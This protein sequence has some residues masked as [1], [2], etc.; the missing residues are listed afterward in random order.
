MLTNYLNTI[1]YRFSNLLSSKKVDFDNYDLSKIFEYYTAIKLSEEYNCEFLVYDDIDPEYKEKNGLT[2]I[3]TGIDLCNCKDTLVQ[4]KIYSKTIELNKIT[5]FL[6]SSLDVNEKNETYVRWKKMI[7]A[8]NSDSILSKNVKK[9]EKLFLDKIYDRNEMIN[10][11]KK[12]KP[13][14]ANSKYNFEE[15]EYQT[16]VKTLISQNKNCVICLPTGTG[17][18]QILIQYL[19]KNEKYLILV[20]LRVLLHQICKEIKQFRFD[21]FEDV[22]LIGDDKKVYEINKNIVICVYNSFSQ[23]EKLLTEFLKNTN[24]IF[25]DEAHHIYNPTIYEEYENNQDLTYI[26]KIRNLK[27]YNNNIYLSATI[28]KIPEFNFYKKDIREMIDKGY[29]SDYTIHIPIFVEPN[30]NKREENICKYLIYNYT[31]IIIYCGNKKDGKR[32]NETLNK[33]RLNCSEYIDCDTS[34]KNRKNTISNFENH[35]IN[36]IV[37]VRVLTEGFN[38]KEVNG[39]CFMKM[40]ANKVALIQIIGRALRKNENKKFANVIIPFDNNEDKVITKFIKIMADNDYKLKESLKKEINSGRITVKKGEDDEN[41]ENNKYNETQFNLLYEAVYDSFGKAITDSWMENFKLLEKYLEKNKKLPERTKNNLEENFI[42]SWT[43]KQKGFIKRN[44]LSESRKNLLIKLAE[45]FN[46]SFKSKNIKSPKSWTERC[47]ELKEYLNKHKKLPSRRLS[48]NEEKSLTMWFNIQKEKIK[49]EKLIEKHK[50]DL[51]DIAKQ[52]NLNLEIKE[53][54]KKKT[55][56]ENF[57]L[58][59]SYINDKSKLEKNEKRR[60]VN[61]FS[62]QKNLIKNNKMKDDDKKE[63]ILNLLT[64]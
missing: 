63:K 16:E 36:F 48:I 59:C 3:D 52:F 7:L 29:I 27:I 64:K 2:Q 43:H 58:L 9:K 45:K 30:E 5:N 38:C 26:D 54:P 44:E 8:R 21:L 4:C 20:P 35:N 18:N 12:L 15:R 22:L 13:I 32:I 49:K 19:K 51:I 34:K 61:W 56:N 23:Y 40:P 57:D 55:W 39:V 46:I 53:I 17:K 62:T 25:I 50:N 24:K 60:I 11:C 42:G 37:N 14:T 33:L 31:N 1:Y 10:F 6:A 41:D 28:D 47:N